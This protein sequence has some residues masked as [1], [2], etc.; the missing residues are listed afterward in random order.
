L[1]IFLGASVTSV[2]GLI[3]SDFGKLVI[4]AFVIAAPLSYLVMSN[5]LNSF[6]YQTVIGLV[7]IISSF[8]MAI[9]I[10]LITI[11]YQVIRAALANP[12]DVLKD[13]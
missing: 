11:G 7:P 6:E 12:V 10:T 9:F 1:F 8:V 2:I 4:V 13:E 3:V 5:W